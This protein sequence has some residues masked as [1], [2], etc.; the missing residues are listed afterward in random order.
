MHFQTSYTTG[1]SV[2]LWRAP[3]GQTDAHAGFSQCMQRRRMNLSSLVRTTEYLW[4]DCTRSAAT[5]AS[6]GSLF[7]CAQ[8]PSHCLQPMHIVASYRMALL[9]ECSPGHSGTG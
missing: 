3:T 2:V 1:P 7:C 4:A 5:A 9:M 8:A 6:E